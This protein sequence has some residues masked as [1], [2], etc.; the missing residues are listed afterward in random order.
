MNMRSI[1]IADSEN[2][3]VL[4]CT[5]GGKTREQTYVSCRQG[6]FACNVD[7]GRVEAAGVIGF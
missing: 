2:L 4:L 6:Q 3:E 5:E 1:P 7:M